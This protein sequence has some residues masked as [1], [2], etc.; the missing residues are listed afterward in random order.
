MVALALGILRSNGGGRR[1]VVLNFIC[2]WI[3]RIRIENSDNHAHPRGCCSASVMAERKEIEL[4]SP[5]SQL[6]PVWALGRDAHQ[7]CICMCKITHCSHEVATP[8]RP[9]C[10][11]RLSTPGSLRPGTTPTLLSISFPKGLGLCWLQSTRLACA[12]QA[13]LRC[14]G[15]GF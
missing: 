11:S 4:T 2:A 12:L 14:G 5:A 8:T 10:S 1:G 6:D 3:L 13:K 7:A 15:F 9:H